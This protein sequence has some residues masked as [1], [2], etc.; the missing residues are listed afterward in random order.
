MR[1]NEHFDYDDD[2]IDERVR[3]SDYHDYHDTNEYGNE[4]ARSAVERFLEAETVDIPRDHRL[5]PAP[6][7]GHEDF[8][9]EGFPEYEDTRRPAP[10]FN[11]DEEYMT[12]LADARR[13]RQRRREQNPVPKPAVRVNVERPR[14]SHPVVIEKPPADEEWAPMPEEDFNSFRE[15]YSDPHVMTPKENE[16][17]TP[18]RTRKPAAK[19]A[20]DAPIDGPNPLRY[21]LAIIALGALVLMSFL[22]INN[23]NLRLDVARHEAAATSAGDYAADIARLRLD[24]DEYRAYI[25]DLRS[26]NDAQAALLRELGH[27]SSAGYYDYDYPYS[28]TEET[29]SRPADEAGSDAEPPAQPPQQPPAQ[30]VVHIVET[31]QFLSHVAFQHFGSSSLHYINLIVEANGLPSA[32]TVYVGQELIIPP[33]S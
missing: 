15:R 33:R 8:P 2:N 19:R 13:E 26:D 31:G 10:K 3:R 7:L 32:D 24:I 20:S 14:R 27:D 28:S 1:E 22:A 6:P 17:K 12:R 21:M 25:A 23:R 9:D 11:D 29:P 30:Q 5:A 18:E 16:A 4:M